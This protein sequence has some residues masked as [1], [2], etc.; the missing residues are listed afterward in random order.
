MKMKQRT[1]LAFIILAL[2]GH[3]SAQYEP[4]RI[5]E[6]EFYGYQESTSIKFVQRFPSTS[7]KNSYQKKKTE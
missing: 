4:I 2:V 5:G 3:A 1:L 7:A 6:I